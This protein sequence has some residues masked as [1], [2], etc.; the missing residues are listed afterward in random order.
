LSGRQL[1][2]LSPTTGRGGAEDYFL[3]V[4]DAAAGAG[5]QVTV[6][7][8][9][10]PG[11]AGIVDELRKRPQVRYA[12]ARVGAGDA[13]LEVA[14]HALAV[15]SLV[16]KV[17]PAAALVVLQWPT[18]SLGALL[19]LARARIPTAVVFQLAPWEMPVGRR[20]ALYRWANSRG[21]AWVAVSDQNREALSATFGLPRERIRTIY[22]GV[23]V[24]A[25]PEA[26]A[27]ATA[28]GS[29]RDELGL[30]PDSRIVLT[31]GRLH[32][33]K[34][35][36]DLLEVIPAT[37]TERPDVYFAWAGDGELRG[38]LESE[39]RRLQLEDRVRILGRREDV[40][41]L[42][43]ASDLFV[44]PS[45][46]E[47][48]PF[49][50]LEAMALGVPSVSSDAGGA[51]EIMRDRVDGL[52]HERGRTGELGRAL[53]WALDHPHDMR[54]MA[55]S[56]RTRAAGFSVERMLAEILATLDDLVAPGRQAGA[57]SGA[58]S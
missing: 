39:L 20:A 57:T 30:P 37:L 21:Q 2:I 6:S 24:P 8:E 3:A 27:V 31:V 4:A 10:G 32:D 28:R 34:G 15:S 22:N 45:R 29:V 14:R 40:E 16:K 58:A 41:T 17:R 38:E 5:W 54:R 33:Q 12:D 44:L 18:A 19:A 11:T 23:R 35:H 55:A 47:G 50:L 13:R 51:P 52:I 25:P 49:A 42:L 46:Y 36:A 53:G 48:H 7:F 9:S 56:A 1:L 43:L 26:A